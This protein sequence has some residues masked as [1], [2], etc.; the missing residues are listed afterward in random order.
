M[1]GRRDSVPAACFVSGWVEVAGTSTQKANTHTHPQTRHKTL[2]RLN[3]GDGYFDGEITS[4]LRW[5]LGSGSYLCRASNG[6]SH[7]KGGGGEKIPQESVE[8]KKSVPNGIK[9]LITIPYRSNMFDELILSI[10]GNL[11]LKLTKKIRIK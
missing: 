5:G 3:S 6:I 10:N 7:G 8:G 1:R 2:Y 11:N 4:P 9:V